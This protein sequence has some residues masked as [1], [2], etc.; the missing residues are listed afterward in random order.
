MMRAAFWCAL[1]GYQH[2]S[3]RVWEERACVVA[4]RWR[5]MSQAEGPRLSAALVESAST[6]LAGAGGRWLSTGI[7]A[8]GWTSTPVVSGGQEAAMGRSVRMDYRLGVCVCVTAMMWCLDAL[9]AWTSRCLA[10][11]T[12]PIAERAETKGRGTPGTRIDPRPLPSDGCRPIALLRRPCFAMA[13][14]ATWILQILCQKHKIFLSLSSSY[15]FAHTFC[16]APPRPLADTNSF[17]SNN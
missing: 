12:A 5:E 4:M 7:H 9:G 2:L 14:D 1:G 16:H 15:F 13:K 17:Q 11:R 10:G 3:T 8:G 6:G